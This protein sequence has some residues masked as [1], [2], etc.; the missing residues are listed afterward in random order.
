MKAVNKNKILSE[1]FLKKKQLEQLKPYIGVSQMSNNFY[2]K[3]LIEKAVLTSKIKKNDSSKMF[4]FIKTVFKP[5]QKLISDYFK[6]R[7]P[8]I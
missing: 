6:D 4:D 2:N 8:M 1:I 5:K 7:C 3:I